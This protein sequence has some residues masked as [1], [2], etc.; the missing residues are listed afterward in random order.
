MAK[1]ITFF[2]SLFLCMNI[3]SASSKA[4]ECFTFLQEQMNSASKQ[5]E[6]IST[7]EGVLKII[8]KGVYVKILKEGAGPDVITEND[9]PLVIFKVYELGPEEDESPYVV[10]SPKRLDLNHCTP[11][12]KAGMKGMKLGEVRR[13]YVHPSLSHGKYSPL[14]VYGAVYYDVEVVYLNR[15]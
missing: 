14:A 3:L 13:I 12:L 15:V 10:D 6:R 1:R 9:S 8:D 4:E 5:L 7:E 11:S 2:L